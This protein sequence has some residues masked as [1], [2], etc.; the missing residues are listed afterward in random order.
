MLKSKNISALPWDKVKW[1][2]KSKSLRDKTRDRRKEK[3]AYN[4][5]LTFRERFAA[6][7][8]ARSTNSLSLSLF[9]SARRVPAS[10]NI[11]D[12][13]KIFQSEL[14][15]NSQRSWLFFQQEPFV[16]HWR[17][18]NN[19]HYNREPR[20]IRKPFVHFANWRQI[21]ANASLLRICVLGKCWKLDLILKL[22]GIT[23]CKYTRGKYCEIRKYLHS[24]KISRCV[25]Y[26]RKWQV[27]H[28]I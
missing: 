4:T 23:Y 27:L 28:D 26:F 9:L 21:P 13:L 22:D 24:V 2:G 16:T 18:C 25:M 6:F 3:I 20:W 19:F 8:Y 5:F 7:V 1:R 17:I 15:N 12:G 14:T 10:C 11:A